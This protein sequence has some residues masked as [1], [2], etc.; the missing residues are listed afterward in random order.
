MRRVSTKLRSFL[1]FP[2][3]IRYSI[4][5][6]IILFQIILRLNLASHARWFAD[7]M[8]DIAVSIHIATE[9]EHPQIGHVAAGTNPIF[10]YP[11]FYYYL[12]SGLQKISTDPLVILKIYIIM[13]VFTILLV[14]KIASLV[15]NHYAGLIAA[16]LYAFS[17]YYVERQLTIW[18][19]YATLPFFLLGFYLYTSGMVKKNVKVLVL[20]VLPLCFATTINYAALILLPLFIIF[21]FFRFRP[22]SKIPVYVADGFFLTM[23]FLYAK[24]AYFFIST[25]SLGTFIAPFFPGNNIRLSSLYFHRLFEYGTQLWTALY[26]HFSLMLI[27]LLITGLIAVGVQRKYLIRLAYLLSFP[28]FTILLSAAK[29]SEFDVYLYFLIAVFVIFIIS[30]LIVWTYDTKKKWFVTLPI[31]AIIAGGFFYSG[32][33]NIQDIPY[34]PNTYQMIQEVTERIAS[35]VKTI[36]REEKRDNPRFFQLIAINKEYDAW[37]STRYYYFL[38]K[39]LGKLFV[40]D[41]H[42]NNLKWITTNDY[43]FLVCYKNESEVQMTGEEKDTCLHY[44][45]RYFPNYVLVKPLIFSFPYYPVYEFSRRKEPSL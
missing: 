3:Y 28:L 13:N 39:Y 4:L 12:L 29:Y 16:F 14:Y 40:I 6:S 17:S 30:V 37:E 36:E 8:R 11:P 44:M 23:I 45:D 43:L 15:G 42:W 19:I 18:S 9:N 26:P 5:G 34:Q 32:Q 1:L 33:K 7:N 22:I 2:P 31:L 41:D 25:Y 20:S 21:V 38:E 35:E 24:F 10:Y 27:V